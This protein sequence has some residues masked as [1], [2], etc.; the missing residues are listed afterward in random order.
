MVTV[1]KAGQGHAMADRSEIDKLKAQAR[2]KRQEKEAAAGEAGAAEPPAPAPEPTTPKVAAPSGPLASLDIAEALLAKLRDD[3]VE[4]VA[5]LEEADQ[6]AVEALSK[7][8]GNISGG[9]GQLQASGLHPRATSASPL[10]AIGVLYD[11][12][13]EADAA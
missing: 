13:P 12:F 9:V 11:D 10:H 1:S 6:D 3:I 8:S 7:R 2:K 4:V 5:R